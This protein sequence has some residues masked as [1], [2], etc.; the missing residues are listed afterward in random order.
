MKRSF[1]ALS[2]LAGTLT[3]PVLANSVAGF[4]AASLPVKGNIG[5]LN[6]STPVYLLSSSNTA[7]ITI[8]ISAAKNNDEAV[9]IIRESSPEPL[10]TAMLENY[11]AA[12]TSAEGIAAFEQLTGTQII[13]DSEFKA[14]IDAR[15]SAE[16]YVGLSLR[17]VIGQNLI[18]QTSTKTII[19]VAQDELYD[20]YSCETSSFIPTK[21]ASE[22]ATCEK[23]DSGVDLNQR[24]I[25]ATHNG[26]YLSEKFLYTDLNLDVT[27][28]Y[29]ED[30]LFDIPMSSA[31]DIRS[32]YQPFFA[33]APGEVFNKFASEGYF[34]AFRV[35]PIDIEE[36]DIAMETGLQPAS[37]IHFSGYRAFYDKIDENGISRIFNATIPLFQGDWY[38]RP[39]PLKLKRIEKE[40][41]YGFIPN[42]DHLET[43]DS[44]F[45]LN[46]KDWLAVGYYGSKDLGV[47]TPAILDLDN[48]R[49]IY[50][51][52]VAIKHLEE[53]TPEGFVDAVRSAII[54]ALPQALSNT[55]P[56][57]PAELSGLDIDP[58]I[59]QD[60]Y[61]ALINEKV[62]R[63]ATSPFS[64]ALADFE[65]GRPID[66]TSDSD[67]KSASLARWASNEFRFTSTT[68]LRA[69]FVS[70]E[71]SK[72]AAPE[73][74]VSVSATELS[75][76]G[77]QSA[78]IIVT[79]MGN[80][81][82]IRATCNILNSQAEVTFS[83]PVPGNWGDVS[84]PAV[85]LSDDLQTASVT[86]TNPEET[87]ATS[88]VLTTT[89]SA[90]SGAGPV[91]VLCTVTGSDM[92]GM[93]ES[94]SRSL[95]F[96]VTAPATIIGQFSSDD[97]QL[98]KSALSANLIAAD[99]ERYS[100]SILDDL[101]FN[102]PVEASGNYVI[103]AQADGYV[104][105]C[106]DFNAPLG[107]TEL[108]DLRALRGDLTNDGVINSIDIWRYYF[109]YFYSTTD[110]DVNSDGN[111]NSD[112]LALIR[113][114]QGA[115][116]CEL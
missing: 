69:P 110:F 49:M 108:D 23:I 31:L 65:N 93:S 79:A 114:N 68:K 55:Y 43:Q 56:T 101:S 88:P 99:G 40:E 20:V 38:E 13:S 63:V 9:S 86:L 90:V 47:I 6:I 92:F 26:S 113:E 102:Q 17:S 10:I 75:T 46:S 60:A 7:T 96:N 16:K 85:Y 53:T 66:V 74:E 36:K 67:N 59:T 98:V 54:E 97:D 61:N 80:Y 81:Q 2:I 21:P 82:S 87:Q 57:L 52:Q 115:A 70:Y 22:Q 24:E 37:F 15:L 95:N 8:D 32:I 18:T 12:P 76:A 105:P 14:L 27:R 41:S 106:V 29:R 4:S 73:V 50:L 107:V 25:F 83:S 44:L 42:F 58:D 30:G 51:S 72:P 5:N 19:S 48:D 111:V 35:S 94:R 62:V 1:L 71:F 91:D 109:R 34:K 116:Q 112:D 39:M 100:V 103:S 11:P 104:M 78:D 64:G 3:N 33:L 77:Q 45:G 28:Y 89:L 84:S